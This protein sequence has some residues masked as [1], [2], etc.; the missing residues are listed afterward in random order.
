MGAGMMGQGIAYSSAMAGIDVVLSDMTQQA[1]ERGK[2]YSEKLLAK[3]VERGRMEAAKA[4]EVLDRIHPSADR[5]DL[6]GC[7]MIIEA[8]FEKVEVKDEV[9]ANTE[10]YLADN[11]VW[12][13]NTSTLPISRLASKARNPKNFVGM[14]FFSPVDKMPLL[15]IIAGQE[16]SDETWR[17]PST[18]PSRSANSHYCRGQD[19][20]THRA[21]SAQKS[22]KRCRWSPRDMILCGW[23]TSRG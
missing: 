16:T 3:R 1:A 15:E 8:V 12:G 22:S 17:A 18:L 6:R 11:G 2:S 14:H 5:E 21:R 7:D 13:S 10:A 4:A 23:T 9:I 19:G 20:L